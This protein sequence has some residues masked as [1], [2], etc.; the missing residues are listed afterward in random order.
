MPKTELVGMGMAHGILLRGSS[1]S[2]EQR[3]ERKR[4]NH[5]TKAQ[6]KRAEGT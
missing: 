3:K 6:K 2:G 1:G 5:G 4:K